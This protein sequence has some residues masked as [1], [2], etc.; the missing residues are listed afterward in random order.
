MCF[1]WGYLLIID[2]FRKGIMYFLNIEKGVNFFYIKVSYVFRKFE[3]FMKFFKILNKIGYLEFFLF[4][5]YICLYLWDCLVCL[6]VEF[7]NE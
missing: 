1:R 2:F 4:L 5:I 3:E 7:L 6:S